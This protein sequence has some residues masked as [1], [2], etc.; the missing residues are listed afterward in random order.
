MTALEEI[1]LLQN[2]ISGTI[3]WSMGDLIGLRSIL[4]RANM[5][6]GSIPSSFSKLTALETLDLCS[7]HLT[8]GPSGVQSMTTFST[9][10]QDDGTINLEHNCLT[11]L[12]ATASN[13][14]SKFKWISL[15]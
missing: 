5:L 12:T 6:S 1:H 15:F 10:T 8:A 14:K 4:M 9:N 7:N 11:F 2:S 13:C 3:P